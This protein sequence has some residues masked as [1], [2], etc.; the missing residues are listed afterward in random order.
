MKLKRMITCLAVALPIA[1]FGAM[2]VN[3]APGK[4]KGPKNEVTTLALYDEAKDENCPVLGEDSAPCILLT[5][6]GGNNVQ[7]SGN[8]AKNCG[9]AGDYFSNSLDSEP[10]AD[11][12]YTGRNCDAIEE[13]LM[14]DAASIVNEITDA[15]VEMNA[16]DG[17]AANSKWC[18]AMASLLSYNHEYHTSEDEDKISGPNDMVRIEAA[19]GSTKGDIDGSIWDLILSLNMTEPTCD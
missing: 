14:R 1:A 19:V 11:L 5:A 6:T 12:E 4:N 2:P 3:A 18:Q 8:Q 15:M 10:V 7:G 16:Q 13:T 17:I 9:G